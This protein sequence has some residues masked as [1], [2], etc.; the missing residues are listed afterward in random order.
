MI[1]VAVAPL[2][3]ALGLTNVD[4]VSRLITGPL[5]PARIHKGFGQIEGMDIGLLPVGAQAPEVEGYKLG[6][7]MRD[8]DPGQNEKADIVRDKTEAL[9]PG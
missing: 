3:T 7:Q 4:P 9:T 2:A 5:K 1:I 6:S 8:T